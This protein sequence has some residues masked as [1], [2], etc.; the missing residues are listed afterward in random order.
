MFIYLGINFSINRSIYL[1][2]IYIPII[3]CI[4]IAKI[5][6]PL[7]DRFIIILL[8]LNPA[9]SSLQSILLSSVASLPRLS[10]SSFSV[11]LCQVRLAAHA[12]NTQAR[13]DLLAAFCALPR[14]L[15]SVLRHHPLRGI[16]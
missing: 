13:G 6:I 15:W 4:F 8:R 7:R 16:V 14:S 5:C 1:S 9:P 10:Y 2:I 12:V 3:T 11:P